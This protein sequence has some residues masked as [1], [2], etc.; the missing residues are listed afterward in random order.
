MPTMLDLG[1]LF[2]GIGLVMVVAALMTGN[3]LAGLAG[4]LLVVQSGYEIWR[5]AP[6]R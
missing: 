6:R 3:T 2:L 1:L 5:A 4:V